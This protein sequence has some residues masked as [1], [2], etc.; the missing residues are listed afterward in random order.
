MDWPA[1]CTLCMAVAGMGLSYWIGHAFGRQA[2]RDE[3][4]QALRDMR[5]KACPHGYVDWDECPVCC[6]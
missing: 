3:V 5:D 6:H 2:E 4:A 1:F